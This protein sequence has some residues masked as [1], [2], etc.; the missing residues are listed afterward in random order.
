MLLICRR[1]SDLDIRQLMQVYVQSNI[2]HGALNYSDYSPD[3]QLLEAEQDFYLFLKAFFEVSNAL[4]FV[5]APN[6]VYKSA[7]RLEPYRDGLLLEGL[8]TVPDGRRKGYAKKL[9][10]ATISYVAGSFYCPIYSHIEK[11]NLASRNL[12]ISCGFKE[13]ADYAVYIDGS[14]DFKCATYK[15]GCSL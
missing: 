10:S 7:L 2:Q 14:V 12:H 15:I 9:L 11:N 4:Y 1:I 6:Y 5:W 13:I 8:E 3:R